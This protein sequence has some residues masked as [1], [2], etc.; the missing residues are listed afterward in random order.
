LIPMPDSEDP[1]E[2][3]DLL[4]EAKRRKE[5]PYLIS[6]EDLLKLDAEIQE[7]YGGQIT[8][9]ADL[10]RDAVREIPKR[11]AA[12]GLQVIRTDTTAPVVPANQVPT[13]DGQ[14]APV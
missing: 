14:A 8:G 10:D 7:R 13:A 9:V 5:S 12:I 3:K 4:E 6:W 2:V 1:E 11:L